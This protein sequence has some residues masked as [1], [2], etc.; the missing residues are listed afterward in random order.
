VTKG[1][2]ELGGGGREMYEPLAGEQGHIRTQE[3]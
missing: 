2:E 3:P 1:G